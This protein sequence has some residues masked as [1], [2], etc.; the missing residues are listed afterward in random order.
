MGMMIKGSMRG[1]CGDA[2]ALYSDCTGGHM[3]LYI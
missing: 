2:I 3:N 1:L